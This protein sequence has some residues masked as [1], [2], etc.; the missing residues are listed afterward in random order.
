MKTGKWKKHERKK[1]M[2]EKEETG[3][4]KKERKGRKYETDEKG[5]NVMSRLGIC[6]CI[7]DGFWIGLLDLLTPYTHHSELQ[8]ITALSL[9]YTLHSSPLHTHK[10]SQSSLVVSWQRIYNS[11]TVNSNHEVFFA[12]PN[13][14][15][16]IIL[17]LTIP[18][19]RLNSVPLFPSSYPCRL[20]FRI[21]TLF[22]AELFFITTLHRPRRKHSLYCWEGVFTLP[23]HSNGSYSIVACVFVVA[24]MCLPSRYLAMNVYSDFAIPAFGRHVTAGGESKKKVRKKSMKG[25]K[26]EEKWNKARMRRKEERSKKGKN[27]RKKGKGKEEQMC[28][29][30]LEI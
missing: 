2:R 20:A 9:I 15:L 16:A 8:A 13:S 10:D 6:S 14:F 21:S 5:K 7:M 28:S 18:K 19:T 29:R 23:L 12:P 27:V 22:S 30:W 11:L 25:R 24:G 4:N 17:Q 1:S 26:V 3:R